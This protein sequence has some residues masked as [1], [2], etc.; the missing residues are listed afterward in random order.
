MRRTFAA[1]A[2]CL[3][4]PCVTLAIEPHR[5]DQQAF[6]SRAVFVEGRVWLL[7]DAGELSSITEGSDKRIEEEALAEPVHDICVHKGKLVALTCEREG[8]TSWSLR[9]RDH[10]TW[11]TGGTVPV[12]KERALALSCEGS[13]VSL[14]TTR[15]LVHIEQDKL[16]EVQLSEPLGKPVAA[17]HDSLAGMFVGF[18]AG[19]W[20]GGLR[21]IDRR[22]GKVSTIE[23]NESGELCGG[24]LNT[25]CDPVNGIVTEPWNGNC[26]AVAIGLVHMTAHGRIVEVCGTTVRSLYLKPLEWRSTKPGD[27]LATVAFFGLSRTEDS[28]WA[29]G[30]DGIYEI[31]SGGTAKI[32]PMPEFKEIGGVYVNFDSPRMV[33]VL[34]Q[35][36]RRLSVSGAV[37]LLV[38]RP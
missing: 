13:G 9:R 28:L 19:E 5:T 11:S 36:N 26:V 34:T 12:R 1:L 33:L 32:S 30:I 2:I 37:P 24:P 25:D 6:I 20:G 31:D 29:S 35:I 27:F 15:R 4:L 14:L 10:E 22:T 38:P 17:V 18:N 16:Q 21:R 3:F 7:T 23:S 8:C